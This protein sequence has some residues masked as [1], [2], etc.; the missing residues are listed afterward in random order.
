MVHPLMR[1]SPSTSQPVAAAATVGARPDQ[2]QDPDQIAGRI[3]AMLDRLHVLV[4]GPGLGRDPLMQETCVRVIRAARQRGMPVVLDAD[5]LLLVAKEPELVK[6]YGLAVLTPNVVEFGRLAKA[7]GVDELVVDAKEREGEEV[8]VEAL[9]KAL[10][11]VMV[12]QKGRVDRLS[13]GR[14]T[15]TVDLAGGKKRSGGQGDTLTG[16]IATFLGWRKAYLDGLWETGQALPEEELVGLAVFGGSAVTRVS[17]FFFR[18]WDER[19]M[20]DIDLGAG[21]FTPGV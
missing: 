21:M 13:D 8:K 17:F 6:G 1:Q 7:L 20:V 11:G 2:D 4:V 5:A 14:T 9:A 18:F 16:C 10:G 12:L 19:M 15:M 3:I